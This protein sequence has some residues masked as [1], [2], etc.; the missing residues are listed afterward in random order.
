MPLINTRGAASIK[1]FGFAGFSPTV[2]GVPTSVSASA[3]TYY[4]ASVTFTA[5]A[6][7]GGLSIDSYIATSCPGSHTGSS[8]SSPISVIGLCGSTSYTFKVKAHNSLGYGACSSSS[9][10]ITTP[11][12]P[13]TVSVMVIGGGGNSGGVSGGGSGGVVAGCYSFVVGSTYSISIGAGGAVSYACL[14]YTS[15]AADE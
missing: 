10:S 4:S 1:G 7:N 2:P 6:C 11:A 8:S 15:D 13:V 14:L 9:N 12:A 3:T 5:P